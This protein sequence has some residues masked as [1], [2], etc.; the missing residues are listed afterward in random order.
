MRSWR[1]L[2]WS[3]IAIASLLLPFYSLITAANAQ[4]PR[5]V[6]GVSLVEGKSATVFLHYPVSAF[7]LY[8][9]H[10]GAPQLIPF[11]VDERDRRDR[12]ALDQGPKPNSDNL[13]GEFDE[14]DALVF[15]NRDLG[16]RGDL[17]QLPSGAMAWGEVRVGSAVEPLGFV[18]IGVFPQ[19]SPLPCAA[20]TVARYD[21]STDRVYAERY[22][23]AF[24][25]PLPTHIAF[26]DKMGDF[27]VNVVAGVHARGEVRFLGGL[28]TLRKTDADIHAE[29]L[30][31][32]NGPV[33]AIRRAR[34]W[35]PLPFGFGTSGQVDLLF[36][37]D[38]VE[39]T[40]LVKIKI[41]PSL[42]LARGE[43]QA[44]FD[45]LQQ[46]GAR[47]LLEGE[48]P[49]APVNGRMTPA[50]QTLTG[51]PARWA[52]LL[53][54]SGRTVL[55]VVRLEG[56]LQRL[57]QR[58]YLDELG[59]AGDAAGGQPLFGF[60]FARVDRLTTGT[61]RLSVFACVLDGID[62]EEIRRTAGVFLSPPEVAVS[63]LAR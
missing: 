43:V 37:R 1:T 63:A 50:E 5:V 44:Y 9:F 10:S 35:I 24:H 60:Q 21:E 61:H 26:V 33:R 15:M 12:W 22:A 31:Y 11:Q 30:G 57:E 28:V 41:P 59:K 4:E 40:A 51:Q 16:A 47:V 3:T 56:G 45:F 34:Y 27:G 13:T 19:S 58:L 6:P 7:R 29:L 2:V 20:C 52:A 14:N 55:L 23:L 39:G 38:F 36:Y 25:A 54:P 48:T 53:L 17:V 42:V 8:A 18:Y 62:T 49:S 46:T 32:R